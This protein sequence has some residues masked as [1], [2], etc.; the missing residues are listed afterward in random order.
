MNLEVSV[1]VVVVFVVVHLKIKC[2]FPFRKLV[3]IYAI[4]NGHHK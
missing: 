2:C 1:D 4:N 3:S